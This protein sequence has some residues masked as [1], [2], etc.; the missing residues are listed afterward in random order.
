MTQKAQTIRE[1]TDKFDYI[2]I[3]NLCSAK[4]ILNKFIR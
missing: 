1:N 2:K 4:D 3:K